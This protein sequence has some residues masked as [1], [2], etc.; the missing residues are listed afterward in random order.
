MDAQARRTNRY[1]KPGRSEFGA[2]GP[3]VLTITLNDFK[4]YSTPKYPGVLPGRR[5]MATVKMVLGG[6]ESSVFSIIFVFARSSWLTRNEYV[7]RTVSTVSTVSVVE[8]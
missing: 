1:P 2:R 5:G 8:V 3:T 4:N 7:V 6:G